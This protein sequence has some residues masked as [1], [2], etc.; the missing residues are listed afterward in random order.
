[1]KTVLKVYD[2]GFSENGVGLVLDYKSDFIIPHPD[3]F[4]FILL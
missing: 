3:Y 2:S 4:R 1:M